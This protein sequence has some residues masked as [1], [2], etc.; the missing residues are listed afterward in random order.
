MKKSRKKP[1]V[2]T[3]TLTFSRRVKIIRLPENYTIVDGHTIYDMDTGLRMGC[4]MHCKH[5][6]CKRCDCDSCE[7][8]MLITP[9]LHLVL[10]P[11]K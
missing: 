3:R 4:I 7:D 11:S 9:P 8:E 6:K 1:S 2:E 10:L 5:A